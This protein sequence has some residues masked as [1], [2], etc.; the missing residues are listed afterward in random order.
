M[1]LSS[2]APLDETARMFTGPGETFVPRGINVP[3]PPSKVR[4]QLPD[5]GKG[6]PATAEVSM[7]ERKSGEALK[8]LFPG[9]FK[10][11]G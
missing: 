11:E 9:L 10:K 1:A 3:A 7:K 8:G 6:A 2:S 4:E 5:L